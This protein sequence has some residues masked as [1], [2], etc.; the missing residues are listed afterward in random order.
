MKVSGF[1]I[2][3][4]PTDEIVVVSSEGEGEFLSEWA[5]RAPCVLVSLPNP[6]IGVPLYITRDKEHLVYDASVS[7]DQRII[8]KKIARSEK[9][10]SNERK[11]AQ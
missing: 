4:G 1:P 6:K 8:F 5:R 2:K 7:R 9:N 10:G 11:S 3:N